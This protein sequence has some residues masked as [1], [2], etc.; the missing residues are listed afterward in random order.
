VRCVALLRTLHLAVVIL[1]LTAPTGIAQTRTTIVEGVKRPLD[2]TTAIETARFVP[3]VRTLDHVAEDASAV[4]ISPGGTR[5]VSR[6]VR[7]DVGR[8]GVW[9]ELVVGRFASLKV[10]RTGEIVAR[11]FTRGY[12][13][14]PRMRNLLAGFSN[15]IVWLDEAHVALRWEDSTSVAQIVSVNVETHETTFLTHY[16]T[17]VVSFIK[18]PKTKILCI[19]SAPRD[20]VRRDEAAGP[21]G[22]SYV[23]SVDALSLAEGDLHSGGALQ[24]MYNRNLF[25]LDWAHNTETRLA[26]EWRAPSAI[27]T[28]E[29][30]W[31][32][33]GKYA[34]ID[35]WAGNPPQAWLGRVGDPARSDIDRILHDAF[36]SPDS[37]YGR[38]LTRLYVVNLRDGVAK[39]L[40]DAPTAPLTERPI[41]GAWSPDGKSVV[42]GPTAVP[43]ARSETPVDISQT[44]VAEVNLVTGSIRQLPL[45]EADRLELR[46]LKWQSPGVIEAL[47]GPETLEIREQHN[48][49]KVTGRHR[50]T[51]VDEGSVARVVIE[52]DPNTPPRMYAVDPSSGTKRLLFDPNPTL[53]G[54]YRLGRVAPLTWRVGDNG[55]AV[56][57]LL[58]YPVDFQKGRRYPLV[59]E[60]TGSGS[61]FDQ[62]N[63]YGA[64][65][66]LGP[67]QSIYAA[68]QLANNGIVVLSVEHQTGEPAEVAKRNY[69][70]FESAIEQLDEDGLIDKRRV[71]LVGESRPGWLVTQAISHSN[72]V[73]AAAIAS[74]ALDTGYVSGT[75]IPGSLEREN[76]G[77]PFGATLKNWLERS[78][79]FNADRI[80]TPLRLEDESASGGGLL[81]SW[82]LFSRLR[83]LNLPVEYY[84]IPN[85]AMGSHVLQNPQQLLAVKEGAVDWLRFWL[86][87][88]EDPNPSKAAV[89]TRWHQLRAERDVAVNAPRPAHLRWTATAIEDR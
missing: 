14:P 85:I 29:P 21:F 76:G 28:A 31:S 80:R 33:D 63:L 60:V 6:L 25:V 62:F 48:R 15:P 3:N 84:V 2:S 37:W 44:E 70:A 66:G 57:G 77:A 26:I 49:W 18:G 41:S 65:F 55:R 75:L 20:E 81:F 56:S 27:P 35:G 46:A 78:E 79:G 71:G 10:I 23:T 82:E 5:Y 9:M 50:A 86:Q 7:G 34:V 51:P 32:P 88:Y 16:T 17:D 69:Q 13:Y 45:G 11:L 30:L 58:Y 22:G 53:L 43:P 36:E 47:V 40:W 54:R 8:D 1:A 87:D 67:S 52:E 12:E 61:R 89:Y 59:I 4:L 24:R 39:P 42:L 73:Y 19:V 68:Q 64:S 72:F 83:S 38:Q 74:D